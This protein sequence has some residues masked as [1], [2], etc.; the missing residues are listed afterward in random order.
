[1]YSSEKDNAYQKRIAN[2]ILFALNG[3]HV[4]FRKS[5]YQ[6]KKYCEASAQSEELFL[7]AIERITNAIGSEVL[8]KAC[9][10]QMFAKRRP[11]QH[12]SQS[13]QPAIIKDSLEAL[14]KWLD[15]V[16]KNSQLNTFQKKMLLPSWM[17]TVRT[18]CA[19][20]IF[21]H[22]KLYSQ[23]SE[24]NQH[25]FLEALESLGNVENWGVRKVIEAL[26][27]LVNEKKQ[28]RLP[29]TQSGTKEVEGLKQRVK[30]YTT[31]DKTA[32]Q[33]L[34]VELMDST[35]KNTDVKDASTKLLGEIMKIELDQ[36]LIKRLTR[37]DMIICLLADYVKLTPVKI[38]IEK[39]DDKNTLKKDTLKIVLDI[40]LILK[41]KLE[42]AQALSDVKDQQQ[43]LSAFWTDSKMAL[44][45]AK[46]ILQMREGVEPEKFTDQRVNKIYSELVTLLA[47]N[48]ASVYCKKQLIAFAAAKL[49][50]K[51]PKRAFVLDTAFLHDD[52]KSEVDE[53]K[54]EMDFRNVSDT[55]IEE[56]FETLIFSLSNRVLLNISA[57]ELLRLLSVLNTSSLDIV[58]EKDLIL[59]KQQYEKYCNAFNE[60]LKESKQ[61]LGGGPKNIF[62]K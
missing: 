54:S 10:K 32:Q 23:L 58:N 61:K 19:E 56:L 36:I 47:K 59:P 55:K 27:C 52:L 7:K 33:K 6:L 16:I 1:M 24:K 13:F 62:S 53:L 5:L 43:S 42:Y 4:A 31:L 37:N 28:E 3:E 45:N 51:K 14:K 9:K 2:T 15:L 8:Q 17:P 12:S 46:N 49:G 34:V 40:W 60:S 11:L 50:A 25:S 21:D 44:Y 48:K 18:A 22:E 38:P 30:G 41:H 35:N 57:E 29:A 26:K 39:S 20:A